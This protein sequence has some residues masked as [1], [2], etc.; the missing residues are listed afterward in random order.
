M[1]RK[2]LLPGVI[3]FRMILCL[4]TLSR[5]TAFRMI[6]SRMI[7]FRIN[8][9]THSLTHLMT[10]SLI[11]HTIRFRRMTPSLMGRIPSIA[12]IVK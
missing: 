7:R 1:Q 6:R 5:M 9:T 8:R 4:M 2:R 11:R 10:P 3:P 12:G